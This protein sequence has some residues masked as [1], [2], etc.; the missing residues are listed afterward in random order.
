MRYRCLLIAIALGL[1][2]GTL[3]GCPQKKPKYPAC[4]S[5]KD[6]KDGQKCVNKTCVQCAEDS[7]C[8]D[9]ETCESG[10]CVAK[11]ACTS[12]E[13]CPPGQVCEDGA[14]RACENNSECGP[15]GSCE[16]GACKR[17]K[18]CK[19]DE[20]C[21]D[22]EDCIDGLCLRPWQGSAPED[23]SCQLATVYFEF[24][25]A[26]IPE[27]QRGALEGNA[28][29]ILKAPADRNVYVEGH[30][31]ESGT[32]EYNIALSDRR[33][34]AVADFMARLGIDPARLNVVPKGES[35]PTG[36]GEERDRRVEFEWQ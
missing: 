23:L 36:E 17:P 19:V 29:C 16:Q 30:A 31:D 34:R 20:D 2:A 33:A 3:T 28:E 11:D 14:C 10:A 27:A 15:G 35:E 13:Q 21:E 25:Q 26:A 18:A 6:C 22:D 24:D 32:E 9:G 7:D 4:A 12:H 5:D 1:A 8:K